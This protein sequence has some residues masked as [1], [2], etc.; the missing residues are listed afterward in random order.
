[1]RKRL[2]KKIIVLIA[3]ALCFSTMVVTVSAAS[4]SDTITFPAGG[5]GQASSSHP[6]DRT[7]SSGFKTKLTNV[8]FNG[9]SP[10]V[11]PYG[12]EVY[13]RLYDTSGNKA[14]NYNFHNATHYANG[15]W[16]YD[17]FLNGNTYNSGTY[18]YMR[19]NSNAT[20]GG[21]VTVLWAYT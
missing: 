5:T 20:I 18:F 15:T 11:F 17:S 19:S 21:T 12:K 3:I 1:M 2:L 9:M 8:A 6:V 7:T 13:F 10:G 4:V 16:K 14:T